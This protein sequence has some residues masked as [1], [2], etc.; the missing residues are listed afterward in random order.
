MVLSAT[1]RYKKKYVTTLLYK[2]IWRGHLSLPP[3]ILEQH[4]PCLWTDLVSSE[5][6]RLI[7]VEADTCVSEPLSRGL[8]F[9][10]WLQMRA[11][12]VHGVYFKKNKN[13]IYAY[14]KKVTGSL[15]AQLF[16]FSLPVGICQG[17]SGKLRP[18]E[19]VYW[20]LLFLKWKNSKLLGSLSCRG[21]AAVP[22]CQRVSCVPGCSPPYSCL[23]AG[24][25]SLH[26]L[27]LYS[28][29]MWRNLLCFYMT[30]DAPQERSSFYVLCVIV[31][32][33]SHTWPFGKLYGIRLTLET[34]GARASFLAQHGPN[35]VCYSSL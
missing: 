12:W 3:R 5:A 19:W 35:P 22:W 10:I 33:R 32:L 16:R 29:S 7:C 13:H 34:G 8:C 6:G 18:Q 26:G 28:H 20:K 24:W 30:L 9:C 27:I 17:L 1:H 4:L 11:L 15:L 31:S 2:P 23:I 14:E 21:S 25:L